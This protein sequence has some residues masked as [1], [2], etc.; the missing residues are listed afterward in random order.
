MP[1]GT[2]VVP[3]SPQVLMPLPRRR[4]LRGFLAEASWVEQVHMAQWRHRDPG[5]NRLFLKRQGFASN[6][7]LSRMSRPW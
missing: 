4:A 3:V 7:D 6:L 5:S 2:F 1:N